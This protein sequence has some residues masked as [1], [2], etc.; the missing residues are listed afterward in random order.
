M[1]LDIT[2]FTGE[3]PWLDSHLLEDTQAK[4]AINCRL[5][6][7]SLRAYRAS[8]DE[9]VLNDTPKTIYLYRNEYERYWFDWTTDV[10]VIRSPVADDPNNRVY[11]TGSVKGPR[12]TDN[13]LALSGGSDY[14]VNDLQLGIPEP[15]AVPVVSLSGTPLALCLQ[16]HR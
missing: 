1:K 7:G 13:G 4:T 6:N 9:Q 2:S 5:T 15:D 14:P 12:Y 10:D 3:V 16:I 11:F 8:L